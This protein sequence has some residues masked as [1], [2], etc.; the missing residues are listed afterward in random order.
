MQEEGF[1]FF[2]VLLTKGLKILSV[3]VADWLQKKVSKT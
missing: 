3:G 1:V 2:P